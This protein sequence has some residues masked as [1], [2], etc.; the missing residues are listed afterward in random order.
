VRWAM[1]ES[2]D[3]ARGRRG[4]GATGRGGDGARG[5]QSRFCLFAPSPRLLSLPVAESP[6]A[7]AALAVGPEGGWTEDELD[8]LQA[9]GATT[10]SLGGRILRAETAALAGLTILQREHGDWRVTR[11]G[12]G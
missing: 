9:A 1:A 11:P 8:L 4:E 12:P 5:R 10:I 2:S 3:G 7:A 6:V